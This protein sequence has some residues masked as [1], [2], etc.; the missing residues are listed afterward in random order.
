[1][2]WRVESMF[3]IGRTLSTATNTASAATAIL[4]DTE[5]ACNCAG[6]TGS[7]TRRKRSSRAGMASTIVSRFSQERFPLA[8]I[9]AWKTIVTIAAIEAIGCGRKYPEGATSSAKWFTQTPAWWV[10]SGPQ[11][12]YQL[13][14]FGIG[15]V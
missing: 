14:G 8:I 11:W 2:I 3:A 9:R 6:D 4:C 10:H 7:S 12:K 5:G 13:N 15:W 1:M